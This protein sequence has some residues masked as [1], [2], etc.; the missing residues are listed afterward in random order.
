[1]SVKRKPLNIRADVTQMTEDDLRQTINRAETIG[2]TGILELA[3]RC[4]AELSHRRFAVDGN[5]PPALVA[6]IARTFDAIFA[7]RGTRASYAERD[8]RKKGI[9]RAI[10]DIV[11]NG[12]SDTLRF[13]AAHEMLDHAFES[14]IARHPESFD[15]ATRVRAAANMEQL[16]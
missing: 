3:A 15:E 8:V 2:T 4:K 9:T 10:S 14:I 13:L 16:K 5:A 7:A 6:D 1:M 11:N 12:V